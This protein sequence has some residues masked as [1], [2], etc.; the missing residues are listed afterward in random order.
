MPA[1][2]LKHS[3]NNNELL[4]YIVGIGGTYGVFG[5]LLSDIALSNN[6]SF[7]WPML[8]DTH[9]QRIT[10]RMNI[11][12]DI[13]EVKTG[14]TWASL[15]NTTSDFD[16]LFDFIQKQGFSKISLV[17]VCG[18]CSKVIYYMLKNYKFKHMVNKMVLLAP[19]DYKLI[20]NHPKHIGMKKEALHNLISLKENKLLSHKFMGYMDISSRTFLEYLYLKEYNTL[21]YFDQNADLTKLKFIDMP[22]KIYMGQYDRAIKD[23]L[24]GGKSRIGFLANSFANAQYSIVKDVVHLFY[25]KEK[26]VVNSIG[27]FFNYKIIQKEGEKENVF[28][29]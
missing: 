21:P 18:G 2:Y 8:E 3:S 6:M 10:K 9:D 5:D 1:R 20:E 7:L 17:A 29:R 26:E 23:E 24:D 12:G 28:K 22:V 15:K 19:E 16:A 11:N 14:A 4:L 25:G 13:E 27:K